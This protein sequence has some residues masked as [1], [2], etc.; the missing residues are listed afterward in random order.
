MQMQ[1]QRQTQFANLMWAAIKLATWT[2]RKFT[3]TSSKNHYALE[4][5]LQV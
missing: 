4:T 1:V 3:G 2:A 5:N